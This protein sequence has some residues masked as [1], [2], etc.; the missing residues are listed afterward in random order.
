MKLSE[1]SA[2]RDD[3]GDGL[4][5]SVNRAVIR[6]PGTQI[7]VKAIAHHGHRIGLSAE[8][9]E[10]GHHCLCF[11]ELIFAAIRHVDRTR[12]DGGVEHFYEALLGA[13]IEI[14]K[15]S[16]QRVHKIITGQFAVSLILK[17]VTHSFTSILVEIILLL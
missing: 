10:L 14:R 11:R 2:C 15:G 13:G 12:A 9:R 16:A 1:I 6:A 3:L 4:R 8:Y 5:H 7:G 17:S